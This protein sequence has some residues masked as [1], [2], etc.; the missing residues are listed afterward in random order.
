MHF[1]F[2][3]VKFCETD[4]KFWW[5]KTEVLHLIAL[6]LECIMVGLSCRIAV[7]WYYRYRGPGIAYC[8]VSWGTMWFPPLMSTWWVRIR[9]CPCV[10]RRMSCTFPVPYNMLDWAWRYLS[11]LE[12]LE[13]TVDALSAL[14]FCTLPI[15]F[16][17]FLCHWF[18]IKLHSTGAEY[19]RFVPEMLSSNYFSE[20]TTSCEHISIQWAN[21]YHSETVDC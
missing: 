10:C 4:T 14:S 8:I 21:C 1:L 15:K 5:I 19:E 13:L 2:I 9:I 12:S 20:N 6:I 17:H 18:H 11:A 7:P 16:F 3:C